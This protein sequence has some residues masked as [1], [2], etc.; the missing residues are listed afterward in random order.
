MGDQ[1]VAPDALDSSPS[2]S[3]EGQDVGGVEDKAFHQFQ[4]DGDDEPTVFK[5]QDELNKFIREGALRH[6]DY[7]RKTQD[8]SEQRKSVEERNKQLEQ[9]MT[10]FMDMKSKYDRIGEFLE[11]RPDIVRRIESE[12]RSPNPRDLQ[13]DLRGY[14]DNRTNEVKSEFERL[15]KDIEEERK[16]REIEKMRNNVFETLQENFEDF[17][18]ESVEKMLQ[19]IEEYQSLPGDQAFRNFAELLHHAK[20]GRESSSKAEEKAFNSFQR[21]QSAKKPMPGGAKPQAVPGEF[22]GDFDA[23]AAAAKKAEG[24]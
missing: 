15:K 11:K 10:A 20:R 3:F 23:I 2:E 9:Q 22:E 16:S 4:F 19:E 21:K 8:L 7:T 6:S 13:Q 1:D 24:L 17:D 18:R 12:M 14:T 5:T